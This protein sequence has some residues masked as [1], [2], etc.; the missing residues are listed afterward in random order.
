MGKEDYRS[1]GARGHINVLMIGVNNVVHF[2]V[3]NIFSNK[4]KG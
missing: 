2:S 4:E 1:R 3:P